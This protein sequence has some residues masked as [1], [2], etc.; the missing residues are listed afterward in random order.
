ML[1]RG[2]R[3]LCSAWLPISPL[4]RVPELSPWVT[5][6]FPSWGPIF[7]SFHTGLPCPSSVTLLGRE[8][9]EMSPCSVSQALPG[10]GQPPGF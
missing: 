3:S 9:P 2:Q 6:T 8:S 10:W 5:T 7:E 4:I 1:P